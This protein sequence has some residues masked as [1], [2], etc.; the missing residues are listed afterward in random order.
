MQEP[1]PTTPAT[2]PAQPEPTPPLKKGRPV[3]YVLVGIIALIGLTNLTSLVSGH[4]KDAPKSA[5]P[6]RPAVPN[7]QQVTSFEQQQALQAR[8]DQEDRLRKQQL[9]VLA[10][11]V[12][13]LK[14]PS[15]SLVHS[16]AR[17]CEVG[18]PYTLKPVAREKL[19]K[20]PAF[21]SRILASASKSAVT[22]IM[23][24]KT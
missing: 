14:T 17:S 4:K 19:A 7:P 23:L 24:A 3:I 18:N 11:K 16:E 6:A 9:A 1:E 13:R 12:P 22:R 21:Y 8:R 5:L 15:G 20:L 2:V 10:G